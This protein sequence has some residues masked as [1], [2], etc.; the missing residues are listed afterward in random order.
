MRIFKFRC[1]LRNGHNTEWL[2]E[3]MDAFVEQFVTE[4]FQPQKLDFQAEAPKRQVLKKADLTIKDI[5]PFFH[6]PIK[7]ASRKLDISTTYLKRICRELGESRWP[8][9][10]VQALAAILTTGRDDMDTTHG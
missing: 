10:K 2:T 3:C 7:D 5:S 1:E 8:Y 9:R 6:M 4:G